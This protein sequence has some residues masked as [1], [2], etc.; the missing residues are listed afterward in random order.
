MQKF[1]THDAIFAGIFNADFSS[2]SGVLTPWDRHLTNCPELQ[3]VVCDRME[4]DFTSLA[5]KMRKPWN[6]K[7]LDPCLIFKSCC[8]HTPQVYPSQKRCHL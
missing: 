5:V 2:A 3:S 6:Q 7:D 8:P 1:L 4:K